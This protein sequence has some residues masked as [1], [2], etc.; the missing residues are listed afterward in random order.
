MLWVVTYHYV[1]DL[2]ATRYPKIKG[3]DTKAF[4]TQ[5]AYLRER[6]E[7]ASLESALAFLAGRYAPPKDLC[8]LTF[9][10]GLK[11]HY[12]VVAPLLQGCGAQGVFALITRCAEGTWVAPAHKNHFLMATSSLQAYRASYEACLRDRIGQLPDA[13]PRATL[14]ASYRWDDLE[15]SK[16]KYMI[17]FQTPAHL[18]DDILSQ[19]FAETI[20]NEEEFA[21]ELYLSFDEARDMQANGMVMAGHSHTHPP[22]SSLGDAQGEEVGNC[23]RRLF[24]ECREQATWPFVYPFGKSDSFDE[25]SIEALRAH[26]FHCAF[27][28]ESGP[29]S[30]EDDLFRLR[31]IDTNEVSRLL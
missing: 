20:G 17:N 28:T 21:R 1:R 26:G 15:T 10:D 7:I 16:L 11:E 4:R 22:L 2:R 23:A 25:Q 5:I 14:E 19:L 18:R 30:P 9:D 8:L 27:S 6:C 3:L 24:A 31:R 29:S 13:V 12:E